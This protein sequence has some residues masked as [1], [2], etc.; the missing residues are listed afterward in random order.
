MKRN[1]EGHLWGQLPSSSWVVLDC[2]WCST[3]RPE[4]EL[5]WQVVKELEVVQVLPWQLQSNL[6]VQRMVCDVIVSERR[7]LQTQTFMREQYIQP[8]LTPVLHSKYSTLGSLAV[9]YRSPPFFYTLE[10][11]PGTGG[12]KIQVFTFASPVA[13]GRFPCS[14]PCLI[15][16]SQRSPIHF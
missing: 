13:E 8:G 9:V 5:L 15:C 3:E 11:H 4:L 10:H 14:K 7:S 1:K 16:T 6:T 12:S 2:V